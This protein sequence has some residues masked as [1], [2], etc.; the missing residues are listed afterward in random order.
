MTVNNFKKSQNTNF[1]RTRYCMSPQ[2]LSSNVIKT[3]VQK[4]SDDS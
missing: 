4:F 3:R 1:L 2:P